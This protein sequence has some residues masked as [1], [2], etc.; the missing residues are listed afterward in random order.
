MTHQRNR[1]PL[2]FYGSTLISSIGSMTLVVSMIGFMIQAGYD[3]V[4][5]GLLIG[6][7]RLVPLMI[8]TFFGQ[9]TDQWAPRKT[10]LISEVLAAL[11]SLGLLATWTKNNKSF[12]LILAF[13]ILRSAFVSIQVGSK[14]KITKAL[15]DSSYDSN[16]K[17]AAWL[18]KVTQGAT[19]FAGI[20]GLFAIKHFTLEHVIVFDMITFVIN[21]IVVFFLPLEIPATAI[22]KESPLQKFKDLYVYN[23][24]VALLDLLLAICMMGTAAF[25]ARLAGSNAEWNSIFL[26]SYG[27]AVWLSGFLIRVKQFKSLQ[28]L[29]WLAVGLSFLTVGFIKELSI[30]TW[31]V[32]FIR[33]MAFWMIFHQITTSIQM[34]TPMQITASVSHARMAQM[35]AVL[36]LGEILVGVW[37]DILP[38]WMEGSLRGALA[39]CVVVALLILKPEVNHAPKTTA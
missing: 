36:A 19:L 7:A 6:L 11:A 26:I 8:S 27:L 20:L 14:A 17:N 21:G 31:L 38:I 1:V 33:D 35:V 30:L 25:S 22:K 39:L 34:K 13:C 4:Q 32:I 15:S 9:K 18:N 10:V 12:S 2:F 29:M 24:R 37:K 28:P 5:V 3:L 16:L 23:G